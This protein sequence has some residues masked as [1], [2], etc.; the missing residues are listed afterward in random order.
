MLG[1]EVFV[2]FFIEAA[3]EQV[4]KKRDKDGDNA[5]DFEE[6]RKAM[7]RQRELF[8]IHCGSSKV[9]YIPEPSM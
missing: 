1:G 7:T 8:F 4:F 5:L 3:A 2:S 6:F 9:L